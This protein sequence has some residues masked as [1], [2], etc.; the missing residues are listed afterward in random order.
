[1]GR[2]QGKVAFITGAAS[3]IGSACALR[4]AQ[5][6]AR[7]IGFD[8]SANADERWKTAVGIAPDSCLETGD[9]RDEERVRAVIDMGAQRFGRIDVAVNCAGLVTRMPIRV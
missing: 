1:M 6:G 9:V 5:E 2:L 8:L 3:G 4:F 7:L